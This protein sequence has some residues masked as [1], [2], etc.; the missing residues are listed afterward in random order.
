M[1][2]QRYSRRNRTEGAE[3]PGEGRDRYR[4]QSDSRGRQKGATGFGCEKSREE[5]EEINMVPPRQRSG[6]T[7][8]SDPQLRVR[9]DGKP[10]Q[11]IQESRKLGNL[12]RN[13]QGSTKRKHNVSVTDQFSSAPPEEKV[14][15]APMK[16]DVVFEVR[17]NVS[18]EDLRP[19]RNEKLAKISQ[20]IEP[21]RRHSITKRRDV[22]GTPSV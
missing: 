12:Q 11:E 18:A 16:D 10:I 17:V 22:R 19:E 5:I 14:Q 20:K 4:D 9:N 15:N 21:A 8:H 13:D 2:D 3:E 7:T 1:R 6:L